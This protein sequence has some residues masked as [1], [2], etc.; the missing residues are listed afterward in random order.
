MTASR[1]ALGVRDL[2]ALTAIAR[3]GPRG[4]SADEVR[5]ALGDPANKRA[6]HGFVERARARGHRVAALHQGMSGRTHL[7]RYA[8]MEG[9]AEAPSAGSLCAALGIVAVQRR[10]APDPHWPSSVGAVVSVP[11]VSILDGRAG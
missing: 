4:L 5:A 3:A 1:K 11:R 6:V 7:Y 2:D 9:E 8:L 10:V